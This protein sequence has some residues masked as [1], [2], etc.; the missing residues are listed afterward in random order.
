[1]RSTLFRSLRR[2]ASGQRSFLSFCAT[3]IILLLVGGAVASG[4][5]AATG[6]AGDKP[7][8]GQHFII[9]T[10]T[11]WAPFEFEKDG[12]LRGIDID[13]LNAI[14]EDQ[15]F[16]VEVRPLGFDGAL[17]AVQANQVA[18]MIAGMSITDERKQTFDFSNPYFDSGI[19][20][21]VAENNTT[22]SSYED[23]KGQNVSAKNGT[24]GF[25]FATQLSQEIGFTVTG[26]QD[27]ADAYNDVTAGNSVATFD[28]YPILAYAIQTG[29]A[30]LKTVTDQERAS[31]YGFAVKAGENAELL[32]MFNDG[33]KNV[34]QSGAYQSILDEYL[35]DNAPDATKISGGAIALGNEVIEDDGPGTLPK[36]PLFA[37][38]TPKDK[39]TFIIATDTTFAPFE[40]EVNGTRQGIDIDLMNAIAANQG[41]EI[42]WNALGFDAAVQAVQ[43]GQA[44]GIIAGMSI[45]DE[46]K[47]VFDFSDDYFQSGIQMAVKKGNSDVASYDDLAGKNVAVKTGTSGAKFAESIK[48]QYGFAI[49]QFAD[50]NDM[51]NEVTTGNSVALFEDY[52]VLQ[53]GIQQGAEL[54][55]VTEPEMGDAYG[56]AVLKGQNA[57]LL[58]MFN[59]GLQNAKDTGVYQTIVDRYLKSETDNSGG[60]FFA[61]LASSMPTLLTGLGYTLLATALSLVFAMILG[62]LFGFMKLSSNW[63]VRGIAS[64][65]VNIFRGTPVLVQAFFF[66]FGVPQLTGINMDALTAGVITLSLNAGAYITET[67]R[68]GIQSVDP[69]QMEASR[70]LGL[71]WGKSMRKVVMP[72]AFKIMTPSLINQFIITLKDTSL[73]SVLGLAELTYQGRIIIASTFRSFEMWIIVGALYFI[74][75]WLLTVLSNYVDRKFNK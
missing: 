26:F 43:A 8:A 65:Y 63:L 58:E 15:G 17:A 57:D 64:T 56:F 34:V 62:I 49:S 14:A 44:D 48:D 51:I 5:Q 2:L 69:G 23:L 66:Y 42:Q 33:L 37:T 11:T 22:V 59:T 47:E 38:D 36:N 75:I 54:Q 40:F 4:A 10:D 67:F 3:V 25:D 41:F 71:G 27:A 1:M 32:S 7:G 16:T 20:M 19:Q 72:Q 61:L 24:E 13:L 6:A 30:G 73:L 46:R 70:S 39:G 53:Y 29:E 74:V 12:Q 28:D 60:G 9:A 31:S 52:P 55:T 21:A 35:G 68:S 18:G 50:S 45:T